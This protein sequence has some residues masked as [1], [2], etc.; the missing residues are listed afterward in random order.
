MLAIHNHKKV[1]GRN[2]V[3]G[4]R[5]SDASPLPSSRFSRLN[6]EDSNASITYIVQ[7]VTDV[8]TICKWATHHIKNIRIINMK[9]HPSTV[10]WVLCD[11]ACVYSHWCSRYSPRTAPVTDKTAV[12][13][14][15]RGESMSSIVWLEDVLFCTMHEQLRIHLKLA[16]ENENTQFSRPHKY[17]VIQYIRT[18]VLLCNSV[19]TGKCHWFPMLHYST[20]KGE[21]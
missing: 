12:C 3:F 17:S 6:H 8:I 15:N 7:P 4:G 5:S 21:K 13:L 11:I 19:Y 20:E 2:V 9:P 10:S 18:Q 16:F 1:F 14:S